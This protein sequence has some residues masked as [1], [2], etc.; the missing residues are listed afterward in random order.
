MTT[1][2]SWKTRNMVILMSVL[3][4]QALYNY[5]IHY[6]LSTSAALSNSNYS[7]LFP[8]DIKLYEEFCCVVC[9]SSL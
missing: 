9:K 2:C 5:R 1:L 3:V 7:L 8:K 4:L 6:V